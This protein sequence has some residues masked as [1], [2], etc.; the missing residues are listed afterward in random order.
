MSS[1]YE[2]MRQHEESNNNA[3]LKQNE[4]AGKNLQVIALIGVNVS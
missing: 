2:G 3:R 4:S 1:G